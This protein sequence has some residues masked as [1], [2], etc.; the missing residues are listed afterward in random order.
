MGISVPFNKPCLIGQELRNIA[1]ALHNQHISANGSFTKRCERWLESH[2]GVN[3]A[4]LVHSCTA[5][6]EMAA[7][8]CDFEPG[9]EVIMPSYT[10]VSTAN[11]FAL[12]GCR[13][14]FVDIEPRSLC[15]DIN[16]VE[17]AITPRTKAVV[18][19]HYAGRSTDMR[20]LSELCSERG[21]VLVEDAAQSLLSTY[22][23]K[24]LGSFGDVACLS[25]HETKNAICGEGGA[26]LINNP[27]FAERAQILR[28]KGTNRALFNRGEVDKYTWVDLG[29]SYG[30]SDL[31]AA[32]LLEQLSHA[33]EINAKRVGLCE[34]YR[35]RLA[36]TARQY[37]LD[38][39]CHMPGNEGKG[40]IFHLM[41]KGIEERDALIAHLREN[42]I[43]AV[44]HYVPLHDSPA[45][46]NYGAAIGDLEVTRRT[47][48]CL[49][50]L[51]VYFDLTSEEVSFVCDRIR[52]FFECQA[53]T[54]RVP[55]S[56]VDVLRNQDTGI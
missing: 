7:L 1:Q 9:D 52:D 31:L 22:H 17:R 34:I 26:L 28:D 56:Q 2:L 21:L 3:R 41:T 8:L 11:A 55:E 20:R 53:D 39:P 44:F 24:A 43:G 46:R 42:G 38:L 50:R 49:V 6:L 15:V 40:H 13:V 23:G 54:R 5:A 36:P 16:Q 48:E 10:F 19:V 35:D 33:R 51:P 12:R 29:S 45:G 32:F 4:L 18:A 30:M 37:G 27:R 25:F 14:I 47:A